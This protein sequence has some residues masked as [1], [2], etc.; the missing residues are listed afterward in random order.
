M[1]NPLE[2]YVHIPFCIKKC[3]YCDFLSAP[4]DTASQNQYL[5]GVMREIAALPE[6]KDRQVISVFVGGGTP[7]AVDERKLCGIL[8]ALKKK[9][10]CSPDAEIT[11]EANPGT[12]SLE[13]L[14]RYRTHGVNRLSLGLQSTEPRLLR[15]LGRIHSYEEFLESYFLARRAGFC[16]VNVD[17]MFA[18]PGQS[19]AD[20]VHT[21]EK[22]AEL[23]P[24]HI[25]AYSLIVEE[26]TPF[27]GMELDLPDEEEEY[28]MYEDTAAVLAQYG[29]EQYEISNYARPGFSCR[30]NE[31]YWKRRDYVGIGLGA[32]SLLDGVRFSNTRDMKAYL[33]YAHEP[34]LLRRD[35]AVLTQ[36][37][38]MEEFM[39]LG[40][41]MT[42]GVSEAEFSEQ[43]QVPLSEV[44][45][46]TLDRY[47][48]LGFLEHTGGYWRFTRAGIHV[49]NR[50]LADFLV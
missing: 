15:R 33:Q 31:G 1:G 30:H 38:K 42:K 24:E 29:Y 45:G 20:W 2:I 11:I 9:F 3:E 47:G 5:D 6:M 21:L 22:V 25:S 35:A 26:G 43:F 23:K 14:E 10:N 39:F 37:E 44:Y 34:R 8:E 36:E 12:L 32:A 28:R 50:I 41:R 19:C 16:N 17:L 48:E 13:K 18:L 46:Q 40:L 27:Y 4:A 7:T 49:S